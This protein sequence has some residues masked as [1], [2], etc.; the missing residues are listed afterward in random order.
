MLLAKCFQSFSRRKA[1]CCK[2]CHAAPAANQLHK[3]SGQMLSELFTSK[4][5]LLQA[6]PRRE[7]RQPA[8]QSFSPNAL[9]PF[10]VERHVVASFPNIGRPPTRMTKHIANS[11]T[12]HSRHK[13]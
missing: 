5:T 12:N 11:Y 7:D 4:G 6:F 1:R 9:R 10:N 3:A 2:L 8:T 13:A